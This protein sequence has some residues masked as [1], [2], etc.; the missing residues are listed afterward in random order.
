MSEA[1][2]GL[3]ER[4][5]PTV[6]TLA[7]GAFGGWAFHCMGLPAA[8]ISGSLVMVIVLALFQVPVAVPQAVSVIG[9]VVLGTSMGTV[10]TPQLLSHAATWPISM[11]CLAASVVATMTGTIFYLRK[12]GGWSLETSFYAAAPGAFSAVVGMA[13]ESG[14]DL[15]RVAFAQTLRLFL[16]VAALPNI[17]G[18]VGLTG[19]GIA[20]PAQRGSLAEVA[21]LLVVCAAGGLAAARVR[22]PGGVI[23]GALLA[24]ATLHLTS[25]S[26]ATLPPSLL[27]PAYVILGANVGVRFRGTDLGTVRQ[28]FFISTGAFLVAAAISAAFA[29][30]AAALTGDDPGKLL[31]AFAPG[32]LE[33]MT[34]LGFAL[35]Y[36]PAFMSA[37][38]IFRFAGLSVALPLIARLLFAARTGK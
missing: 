7:A 36:D 2:P 3:R 11:A 30:L 31:T 20:P 18:A 10:L 6:L 21:L 22:L 32:A 27:L 17:L 12:V 26:D 5:L 13:A 16:L 8:W 33:A 28:M 23:I 19:T 1:A 35:G 14:A 4:I 37:H 9:F 29:L 15:R 25:V 24:S 34:A 38:H